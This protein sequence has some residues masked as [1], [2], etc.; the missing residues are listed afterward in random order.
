MDLYVYCSS[1]SQ[2]ELLIELLIVVSQ[3]GLPLSMRAIVP[4]FLAGLGNIMN[5]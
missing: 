3:L 4:N 5:F 1:V 2:D